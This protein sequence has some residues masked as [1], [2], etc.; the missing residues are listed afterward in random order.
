MSRAPRPRYV[1]RALI[2]GPSVALCLTQ[3]IFEAELDRLNVPAE[4]RYKMSVREGAHAATHILK[5]DGQLIFLVCMQRS[6]QRTLTQHYALLVHEAVHIWRAWM[7][8]IGEEHP[9]EEFEAYSLQAIS[10]GLM[11]A[12]GAKA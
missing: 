1:G 6:R 9:S 5:R 4:D 2:V 12:L 11:D 10:Q 8:S 7:S 3:A